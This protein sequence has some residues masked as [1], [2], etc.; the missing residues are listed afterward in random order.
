MVYRFLLVEG[1]L[2]VGKM[3]NVVYVCS[4]PDFITS[5]ALP[6]GPLS[7]LLSKLL[8]SWY[9]LTEL[10]SGKNHMARN[11]HKLHFTCF[12]LLTF[13]KRTKNKYSTYYTQNV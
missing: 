10:G 3:H 4:L 1:V 13:L 11:P 8:G 7:F 6:H 12:P 2:I 5:T 9:K